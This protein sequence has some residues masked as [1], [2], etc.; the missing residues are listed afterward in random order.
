MY[1]SASNSNRIENVFYAMRAY[2]HAPYNWP[3]IYPRPISISRVLISISDFPSSPWSSEP[4]VPKRPE[5]S[6]A[7]RGQRALGQ[8]LTIPV[9][10]SV[11]VDDAQC[12]HYHQKLGKAKDEAAEVADAA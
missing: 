9:H 10:A 4:R 8:T 1:L 11:R 12:H 5:P 2:R 3:H 7:P 6:Q